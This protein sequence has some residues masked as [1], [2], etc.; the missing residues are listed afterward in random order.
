MDPPK[1]IAEVARSRELKGNADFLI[2][3]IA[4]V[5]KPAYLFYVEGLFLKA[6]W[7]GTIFLV[8]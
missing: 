1:S 5:M 6:L 3:L 7:E 8:C 2:D 4:E